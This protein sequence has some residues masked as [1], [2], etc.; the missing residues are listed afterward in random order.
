M[1]AG[2]PGTALCIVPILF[3]RLL[4]RIFK[5]QDLIKLI[6]FIALLRTISETC[7]PLPVHGGE[8]RNGCDFRLVSLSGIVLRGQQF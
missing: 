8:V 3:P 6:I 7:C 2:H 4:K 5:G 1:L